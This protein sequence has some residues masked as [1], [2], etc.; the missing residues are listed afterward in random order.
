[1]YKILFSELISLFPIIFFGMSLCFVLLF[2]SLIST[3]KLV[4]NSK[5]FTFNSVSFAYTIF[6]TFFVMMVVFNSPS[7]F[8]IQFFGSVACDSISSYSQLFI[9]FL[10]L[11]CLVSYTINNRL[12][13]F[14]YYEFFYIYLVSIF[15]I[16]I[17]VSSTDLISVYLC[18]ELQSITIYILSASNKNSSF[19]IES[20]LK[21]LI[22]GAFS[23]GFF[24]FGSSLIYG[25]IGTTNY[26]FL[27]D[28]VN[29]NFQEY[30]I[31]YVGFTFVF[32][33][34]IFKLG[35]APFHIW[36][37]DIIEGVEM[38]LSIFIMT[39]SKFSLLICLLRF[40]STHYLSFYQF[41]FLFFTVFSWAIGSLGLSYQ[42]RVK[43]FLIFSSISHYGFV[44]LSISINTL[45]SFQF[46]FIYYMVYLVSSILIFMLVMCITKKNSNV[47]IFLDELEG[48]LRENYF[49]TFCFSIVIFSMAGIPPF[50][51][52]F[53]KYFI[54]LSFV[55]MMSVFI[56]W[57][58]IVFSVINIFYY[59]KVIKLFIFSS[60]FSENYFPT[61]YFF[62][63][64]S[65]F[66]SVL[67]VFFILLFVFPTSLPFLFNLGY[68]V[69]IHFF[70]L[71]F[72]I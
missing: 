40:V 3:Q 65:T 63:N 33:S 44:I 52:F 70:F 13:F 9:L 56:L 62:S 24:L 58:F 61:C 4:H 31:V 18:L 48:L 57:F 53:I 45:C 5:T 38:S 27:Q 25:F 32:L 12:S 14:N 60:S 22:I 16:F 17:L 59:I 29:F 6:I 7:F 67:V 11:N 1:M 35:V 20:S 34:I 2:Y 19:S 66:V 69:S 47:I 46:A 49:F 51:G 30:S 21:Y 72:S 15:S 28:L 42:K 50:S 10:A 8:T 55:D 41:I 43:R 64:A 26:Y 39:A 37:P 23:S 54:I 68:Y 71:Y 36:I